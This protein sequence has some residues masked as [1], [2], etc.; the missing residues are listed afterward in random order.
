MQVLLIHD[1]DT[2]KASAA[3][4]V[5]VGSL[6]DGDVEGLA[7]FC[8]HML[9]LGTDKFP[10]EQSYSKYLNVRG[11]SGGEWVVG[12]VAREGKIGALKML[13]FIYFCPLQT[14]I[15]IT[16]KRRAL[17]RLHRH[18]PHQLLFLRLAAFS[19]RYVLVEKGKEGVWF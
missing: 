3:M 12:F 2:D 8:E 17:Q 9:F 11:R 1:P 18:G 7:H 15:I 16:A 5:G 19:G 14:Q 10:D 13:P 6:H 4:D